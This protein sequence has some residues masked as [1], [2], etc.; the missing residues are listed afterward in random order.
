MAL[1]ARGELPINGGGLT[2]TA[3]RAVLWGIIGE[4]GGLA[5]RPKTVLAWD[6]NEGLRTLGV[7]DATLDMSSLLAMMTSRCCARVILAKCS[8]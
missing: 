6:D 2:G 7:D 8:M 3:G 4:R 5:S 1:G